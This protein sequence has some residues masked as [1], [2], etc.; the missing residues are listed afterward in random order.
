MCPSL[1]VSGVGLE[2]LQKHLRIMKNCHTILSYPVSNQR[3][4][5]GCA[6]GRSFEI[7]VPSWLENAT[8]EVFVVNRV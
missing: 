8:L 1:F 4:N 7:R 3:A 2:S 5:H 6:Q